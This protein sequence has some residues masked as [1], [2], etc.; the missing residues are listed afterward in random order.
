ML[1]YILQTILFQLVFLLVYEMFLKK[2]T[3]FNWNR[4]YLLI[5]AVLS[6][7]LP[8]IKVPA[9]SQVVPQEY[10]IQLPAVVI[11]QTSQQVSTVS[12]TVLESEAISSGLVWQW[13]YLLWLGFICALAM[14]LYKMYKIVHIIKQNTILKKANVSLVQLKDSTAAFSFFNYVFIGENIAEKEQAIILKHE[15]VHVHQK[16]SLDLLFF[17]ILRVL[18]WF[19]P[20]VY[21]YQSKLRI[22]HEYIADQEALKTQ[23]KVSYYQNLL[24]QLFDTQNVSFINTFYK[25]SL[26]K[27]RIVMLQKSKS[28]QLKLVKYLMVIPAVFAMLAYNA[29]EAQVDKNTDVSYEHTAVETVPIS[30]TITPKKQLVE[31]TK[32][33]AATR[34]TLTTK[35]E[36]LKKQKK[37]K[38]AKASE[39]V[40]TLKAQYEEVLEIESVKSQELGTLS[41]EEEVVKTEVPFAVIDQTPLYPECEELSKKEQRKCFSN[42]VSAH[43]A[44]NFNTKLAESVGLSG[45]QRINVI[46]KINKKGVVTDVRARAAHPTL[47]AEAK[48]V[49]AKLPKMIPGKHKGKT[50]VVP[51]SLPIIFEIV[52]NNKTSDNEDVEVPFAVID[53]IPLFQECAALTKAEQKSCVENKIG[54]HVSENFN[55]KLV[56]KLGLRG[57]KQRIQVAFKIDKNGDVVN[58]RARAAH[59]DLEKEAARVVATIPKM[60]PGKHKGKAVTVP[61]TL[62]IVFYIAD[63]SKE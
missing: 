20:L 13:E 22:L 32:T 40:T 54:A 34:D 47:E 36:A 1:H 23:D 21:S 62:P 6:L 61:Y 39:D 26:I 58:V 27:K 5:T 8:F 24:T 4:A 56:E 2:E 50:V 55:M 35:S 10:I 59:S 44:A 30:E 52:G 49:V 19:N 9:F 43:V 60:I 63:K 3:F 12:G 29:A 11:G 42:K 41:Q 16:H 15:L 33:D 14:L 31:N 51:Y 7:L 57:K 46:F 48:R 28:N 37:N 17:E 45:K 25:K 53:Q 38:T 18:F